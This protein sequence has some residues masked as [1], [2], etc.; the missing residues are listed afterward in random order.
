MKVFVAEAS[1]AID[2]KQDE[3][4]E[5]QAR[6]KVTLVEVPPSILVTITISSGSF[7]FVPEKFRP[8]RSSVFTP[9]NPKV[10]VLERQRPRSFDSEL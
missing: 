10:P 5:R 6:R 8:G 2:E 4:R 3:K 9:L 7:S 1:G